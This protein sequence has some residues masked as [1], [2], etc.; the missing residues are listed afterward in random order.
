[1]EMYAVVDLMK[2]LIS[3]L[4]SGN[5]RFLFFRT[6][7]KFTFSNVKCSMVKI[8]IKDRGYQVPSLQ[9]S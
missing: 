7:R 6:L 9:V 4:F 8:G 2:L 5:K 1:M 3:C